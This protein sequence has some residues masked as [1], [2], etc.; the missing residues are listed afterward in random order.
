VRRPEDQF[1]LRESPCCE[2]G[3]WC[4]DDNH[5]GVTGCWGGGHGQ[6]P[7][8]LHGSLHR[9]G[10]AVGGDPRG[11]ADHDCGHCAQRHGDC[12]VDCATADD[13]HTDAGGCGL[14]GYQTDLRHCARHGGG[15]Y[16]CSKVV[17]GVLQ[18]SLRG[19]HRCSIGDEAARR[20]GA[21][22]VGGGAWCG[23]SRSGVG[24]ATGGRGPRR[25]RRGGRR[26]G[27]AAGSAGAAGH[28]NRVGFGCPLISG[29]GGRKG[30]LRL[31]E[32]V[33]GAL[34]RGE[35]VGAGDPGCTRPAGCPRHP[36]ARA[37]AGCRAGARRRG[38]ACFRCVAGG[39]GGRAGGDRCPERG[40]TGCRGTG[41]GLASG[42]D[43]RLKV[44]DSS[45]GGW[46]GG[47]VGVDGGLRG[48][49]LCLSVD[50]RGL[51]GGG[52][53]PG[54]F[55]AGGDGLADC[56]GDGGDLSGD[57]ERRGRLVHVGGG[58][59]EVEDLLHV[60]PPDGGCYV[61]GRSG[62]GAGVGGGC[63]DDEEAGEREG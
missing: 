55:L 28:G 11:A 46:R 18:R 25:T 16:G 24:R 57:R 6:Q 43:L 44:A 41:G 29:N 30:L 58:A 4:G 56:H 21:A 49:E 8:R 7:D 50:D 27:R 39:G 34:C 10:V 59:G 2:R 5:H 40:R 37:V 17:I 42:V 22:V 23:Q 32:P 51:Q 36:A 12:Y 13:R 31:H 60:A 52:V 53:Q 1:D 26:R 35:G 20:R 62:R 48:S 54:K 63:A 47:E 45:R 19:L 61:G 38:G 3:G 33:L 14:S 15:Q 9:G